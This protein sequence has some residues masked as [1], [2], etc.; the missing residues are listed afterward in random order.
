MWLSSVSGDVREKN[1][2]SLAM[3]A[4]NILHHQQKIIDP[5]WSVLNTIILKLKIKKKKIKIM[6]FLRYPYFFDSTM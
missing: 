3:V 6:V 5:P 4:D 1:I 2:L